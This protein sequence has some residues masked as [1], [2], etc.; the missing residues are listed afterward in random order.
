MEG[1]GQGSMVTLALRRLGY[2]LASLQ[3]PGTARRELGRAST[4]YR[5]RHGSRFTPRPSTARQSGLRWG[6]IN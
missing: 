3:I 2:R 5:N 4:V 1:A 6:H